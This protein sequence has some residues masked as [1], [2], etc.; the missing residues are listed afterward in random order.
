MLLI[1]QY[2]EIFPLNARDLLSTIE[3]AGRTCYKS[4]DKITPASSS[5]FVRRM[6]KLGHEAM[7]EHGQISFRIVTNRGVTHELVRHRLASYAQESTRYCD[8]QSH[9]ITF[10]NPVWS[11][12]EPSKYENAFN[13]ANDQDRR[14]IAQM[15]T[16]EDS[17]KSLRRLGW[18]P[19]QAR[20]V[21]PNALK[22]EIIMTANPREWRHFLKLRCHKTAHPQ[23][24]GIAMNIYKILVN[25]LPELF[26]DL[27][28][29]HD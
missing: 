20:E 17:Y 11:Q 28:P 25:I 23:M 27:E 4:E 22:T 19:Q 10:I 24:R 18:T 7:I 1:N 2:V 12:L 8:Y 21:L 9:D 15:L 5:E 14:F 3:R 29:S 26:E 16:A 13:I 6:I